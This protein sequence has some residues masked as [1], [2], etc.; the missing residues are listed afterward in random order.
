ME[1]AILAVALQKEKK[2]AADILGNAA[3][4]MSGLQS[5]AKVPTGMG[6][7]IHACEVQ[8]NPVSLKLKTQGG[9]VKAENPQAAGQPD[10]AVQAVCTGNTTLSFELYVD[11]TR[12]LDTIKA[13]LGMLSSE[14]KR[15]VLFAWGNNVFAG[16]ISQMSGS[17]TMF[18]HTGQPIQGKISMTIRQGGSQTDLTYWE[19]AFQKFIQ[20]LPAV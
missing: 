13:M 17:Y 10:S 2:E 4:R 14:E 15:Q 18:D 12:T 16:E 7:G 19:Q 8:Y 6:G 5:Q 11:G 20:G 9:R 3:L 1:K